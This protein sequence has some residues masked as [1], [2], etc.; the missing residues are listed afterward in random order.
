[1]MG[2]RG[3]IILLALLI[4]LALGSASFGGVRGV[5][6][7]LDPV[8]A[9]QI[10][11]LLTE[12]RQAP[13]I[14][15]QR[16]V[17]GWPLYTGGDW[18][19]QYPPSWGVRDAN[20]QFL[21]ASDPSG[22]ANFIFAQVAQV[23]GLPSAE[24]LRDL[25][26]YRLVGQDPVRLVAMDRKRLVELPPTGDDSGEATVFIVRWQGASGA[27]MLGSI[28]I[29]ILSRSPLATAYQAFVQ[30]C[31]EAFW[32]EAWREIFGPMILSSRFTIPNYNSE[33]HPDSDGDGYAD[34][35]DQ[36]PEDPNVH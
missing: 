1:M 23:P 21:W 19:T 2:K 29:A 5:D 18:S 36:D 35:V 11:L 31:P 3:S 22:T 20:P 32:V 9:Q 24:E 25:V 4:V 7:P 33:V 6:D 34:P 26:F 28:Q 30:S 12:W 27:L 13:V 14:K 15:P 10:Q 16:D 8:V 17:P